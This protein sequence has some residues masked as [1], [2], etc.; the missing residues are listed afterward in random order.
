MRSTVTSKNVSW[1]RL[2]WPT[3]CRLSDVFDLGDRL[4]MD[5]GIDAA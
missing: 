5:S 4:R 2:I 1:P 3:L